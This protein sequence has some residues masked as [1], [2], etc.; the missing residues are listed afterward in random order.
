MNLRILT[1]ENLLQ[2]TQTLVESERRITADAI[3]HFFEIKRR[4]LY[5]A[6]GFSSL[7]MMLV[8]HYRYCPST[9]MLRVNAVKLMSDVPEIIKNIES[10]E[11][12]VSVV[13]NIQSFL[14]SEAK[15]QNPYSREAKV[16]LFETCLGKSVLEVQ[17]EFVRRNPE[18]EKRDSI[19]LTSEDRLRVSHSISTGLEEKLQRIKSLWSQVDPNMSREVMLDRM[20]ELTLDQID[21]VRKAERAHARK[22]KQAAQSHSLRAP[23]VEIESETEVRADHSR[24]IKASDAHNVYQQNGNVGCEF[25][26]EASGRRCGSNFQLQKDHITPWSHGGSNDADN[27]RIYCANHNRWRWANRSSST[28]KAPQLAYG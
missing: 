28:V 9:A 14:N 10:G 3:K 16:E 22:E 27:L 2:A 26:D 15:S 12:P 20:A 13:A 8:K 7:F 24:Y 5:L 6:R 4:K 21:P 19:R 11:M 25:V 17:K 23:E 18:L 1:D